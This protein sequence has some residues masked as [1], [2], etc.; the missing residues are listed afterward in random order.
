M[1]ALLFGRT[2]E[3]WVTPVVA[4]LQAAAAA[5]GRPLTVLALEEALRGGPSWQSVERLYVLPFD[6][7]VPAPAGPPAGDATALLAMLFPRAEVLNPP[8]VHELCWDKV[9]AARR[10]LD[11]GV[12]LPETLITND[13]AEA[14]DFVR[15]HQQAILKAPRGAGGHGHVIVCADAEGAIAGEIPGRRYAVEFQG[16]GDGHHL[17]HGVLSCAPPFFLQRLVTGLGRGGV[18][19]P[20]Q[21]LRAYVVD[22]QVAFWSETVRD[23]VRRPADFI[24]SLPFG[25]RSRLLRTAS[26]AAQRLARRASDALGLR[27]GVVDLIRGGDEGP[28]VLEAETDGY[29]SLIDRSFQQLPEWRPVFDFDALIAEVLLAAPAEI[30]AR[31]TA[32]GRPPRPHRPAR[33]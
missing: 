10:L 33:R 25:A 4:A 24:I 8:A 28:F 23:K 18:L 11:R 1:I 2:A 31:A 15:F 5:R 3:P 21:I 17:Q 14:R 12:A 22:G 19:Q 16:S 29:H 6:M 30:R 32:A 7:P 26:D 13:P 27:I 9:A 20:A